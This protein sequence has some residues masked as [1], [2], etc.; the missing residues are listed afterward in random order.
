MSI[1]NTNIPYN[2]YVLRQD[3]STLIRTFPFLN[4]QTVGNS[5][6][7]ED[8]FVVKLGKGPKKVFYSASIHAKE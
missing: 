8:I 5:V 6:L 7:G 1:V 2:Y 4:I 3:L